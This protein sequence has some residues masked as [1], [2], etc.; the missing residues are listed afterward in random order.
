M[1]VNHSVCGGGIVY[2]FN[3][4]HFSMICLDLVLKILGLLIGSAYL[5][6]LVASEGYSVAGL[7]LAKE[8][9]PNHSCIPSF[10]ALLPMTFNNLPRWA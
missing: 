10:N 2:L 6:D 7:T 5:M 8:L 4:M 3:D 1:F 9:S